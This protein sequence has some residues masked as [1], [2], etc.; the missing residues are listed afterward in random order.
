[1]LNR[2]RHYVNTPQGQKVSAAV[3]ILVVLLGGYAVYRQG[4]VGNAAEQA[5]NVR[6]FVDATTGKPFRVSMSDKLE[7]PAKAPSGG[8]TG[9][10]AEECYWTADGKVK[11]TPTYVLVRNVWLG[12]AEPTFCPDCGRLVVGHNPHAR[13][14]A[15]PPPTKEEFES[16]LAR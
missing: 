15:T 10:P 2:I 5:A 11:S 7:I 9:Y 8:M 13:A 4:F 6:W 14:G 3:G 1:M 16:R 12:D